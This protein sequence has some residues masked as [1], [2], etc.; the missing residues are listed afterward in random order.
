MLLRLRSD[1]A[2]AIIAVFLICLFPRIHQLAASA[3]SNALAVETAR[4]GMLVETWWSPERRREAISNRLVKEPVLDSDQ[5]IRGGMLSRVARVR[6][7]EAWFRGDCTAAAQAWERMEKG[8]DP[9]VVLDAVARVCANQ[10]VAED[11]L[12]ELELAYLWG[13]AEQARRAGD[14]TSERFW[15]EALLKLSDT[16]VP[17]Y[18]RAWAALR[19]V[20]EGESPEVYMQALAH[21]PADF[22]LY[23]HAVK[24]AIQAKRYEL[25]LNLAIQASKQSK[26][27]YPLAW[28]LQTTWLAILAKR[29]DTAWEWAN[30]AADIGGV[31]NWH[32]ELIMAEVL[33]ARG[34]YEVA[35]GL[36]DEALKKTD[37]P[38][39]VLSRKSACLFSSGQEEVG[40]ELL[41]NALINASPSQ[42]KEFSSLFSVL[43]KW[44]KQLGQVAPE[45]Y[46]RERFEEVM[47]M[48]FDTWMQMRR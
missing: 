44:C 6:G 32:V 17:L 37:N 47:E 41:R 20:E 30:R 18:W 45:C 2:I 19:V 12:G 31:D 29:L 22:W 5:A 25:A 21:S 36:Y 9:V 48:D 43:Y 11:T 16:N 26:L 10:P 27:P 39:Y 8:S 23:D 24:A 7:F 46:L 33:C 40:L 4:H 28:A 38:L 42:I 15:C 13:L 3:R 34:D 14:R 1:K 35:L